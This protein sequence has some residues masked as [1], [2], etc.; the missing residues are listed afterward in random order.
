M[1]FHCK[2]TVLVAIVSFSA[3]SAFAK[4]IEIPDGYKSHN[5]GGCRVVVPKRNTGIVGELLTTCE[6]T[7]KRVFRQIG[8]SPEQAPSPVEVRIVGEPAH[9]KEVV[10]QGMA[11]P[12]W[13]GAVAYP[14]LGLIILAL[15]NSMGSPVRDLDV[16][17]EH[18]MSHLAVRK[19]LEG[20]RV[21]RWLSEGI[22]VQQSEKSSFR[23]MWIVWLAARGNSLLPLESIERYPENIDQINLA[24]AQAADFTG[25]LL[26]R[27]GW[28][29]IRILLRKCARSIPFEEAFEF[30]FRDDISSLE[31]EWHAGLKT[32][33]NWLPLLTGTG[34]LWGAIVILFLIA[35]ALAKRKFR[36]RLREMA[37]Q[38]EL[39]DRLTDFNKGESGT[40]LHVASIGHPPTKIRVDD[41]IH[42]LH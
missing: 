21:P 28:L 41:E 9:M 42:T 31:K 17:L 11:P 13:S 3:G 10:P 16:V 18:E 29:G 40:K 38:E 27:E 32:R 24:Y 30:A 19:A 4:N 2:L 12:E 6:Q 34:A 35:Y 26:R 7:R 1:G 20:A 15:R 36:M 33:W 37:R 22:A 23:R 25:F 8:L 14:E 5:R 39:I